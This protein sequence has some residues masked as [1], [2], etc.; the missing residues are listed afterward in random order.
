MSSKL[1]PS[2]RRQ[3]GAAASSPALQACMAL[4]AFVPTASQAETEADDGPKWL[5]KLTGRHKQVVD[6]YAI[7]DGY[8][9]GFVVN[10]LSPNKSASGV[11]ILRHGAFPLTLDD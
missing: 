3:P 6:A 10:F 4:A 8:P 1:H 9:L 2:W 7:N 5:G 11:I